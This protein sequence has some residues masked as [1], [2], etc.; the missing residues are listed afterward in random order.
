[1]KRPCEVGELTANPL[2]SPSG[3]A[4]FDRREKTE[5][6]T[7]EYGVVLSDRLEQSLPNRVALSVTALRSCATS[8]GGR[9]KGGRESLSD[10]D[11]GR[12]LAPAETRR[13]LPTS[14]RDRKNRKDSCQTG[15]LAVSVFLQNQMASAMS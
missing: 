1:M 13:A 8:P 4:G 2:G 14:Y 3:G 6:A 15:I 5:R 9:G 12:G 10:R 11:V 7:Q